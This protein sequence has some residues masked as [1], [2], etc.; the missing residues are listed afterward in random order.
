MGLHTAVSLRSP[1]LHDLCPDKVYPV[2]QV[3]EQEDP[4]ARIEV[5]AEP[6]APLEMAPD[7][8]HEL[9]LHTAVSLRS[10]ALHDLC[11][12]KVYPV[13]QVGEQEDPC[14]RIEVQPGP[15]APLEME[16]DASHVVHG[17]DGDDEDASIPHFSIR[18]AV[19]VSRS[20]SVSLESNMSTSPTYCVL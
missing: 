19:T 12:D 16:S 18:H 6:G 4:C 9:G 1:A 14:A 8:S 11:P 15:A 7:A 5:Q 17:H 13:L 2:L 3:G 20:A 10:P